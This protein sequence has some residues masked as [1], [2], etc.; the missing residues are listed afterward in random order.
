M[1][2]LVAAINHLIDH[3][4]N[5]EDVTVED[6]MKFLP[7]P[8]FP[9]G[10]MIIGQ[11]SIRQAYSTGRGRLVVR[12]KAE[13]EEFKA[14][15]HAIIITEIPYQV[16]KTTMLER[17]AALVREGRLDMISDMRDESDRK[18]MRIV[19]ELKRGAQPQRVLNQLYKY[20]QLQSTF[21]V[22]M[23]SLI[24]GEPR[25]LP[26]RRMLQIFVEHRREVITRRTQFELDKAKHRA[27]VLDGLL[28]A[29][30]NLDDV[31]NTIRQAPDADIA[32]V[33]LISR[34]NL[35][36]IQAQAILDMQLR[37]L[38]ALERQKIE[39]E[40][41]EILTTIAYLEDL[42]A[43]PQKILSLIKDDLTEMSNK[44]GDER[45]TIISFDTKELF[46]E[47][48]LVKDEAVLITVTEK[49]YIKRTRAQYVPHPGTRWPWCDW[50]IHAR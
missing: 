13:I 22:N 40:H 19:V 16:N 14:G 24:N 6:L 50:T 45:R 33:N 20:T 36:E 30:A 5:L 1:R 3:Y 43:N 32:K 49:G 8:D 2:E 46:S 44:Y 4:E 25:S 15:R 39:D 18:G 47:A 29:L 35:S 28:I 38:A 27:H 26:L 9:T 48:E 7:G 37:R 31:I 11:D 10:G 23:L 41:K 42:L 17:I 12:G 21:G 34:F